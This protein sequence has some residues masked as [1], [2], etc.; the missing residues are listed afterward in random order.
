M[1]AAI[2]IFFDPDARAASGGGRIGAAR[3]VS[4]GAYRGGERP[5]RAVAGPRLCSFT[6]TCSR[7]CRAAATLALSRTGWLDR[8]RPSLQLVHEVARKTGTMTITATDPAT[9]RRWQ[10]DPSADLG[11]RQLK[12]PLYVPGHAA[13]VHA[14]QTRRAARPG[15]QRSDHHRRLALLAERRRRPP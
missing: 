11:D 14:L 10:I 15:R 6:S 12:K 7:S 13:A 1:T 2:T 8:G 5:A 9:G 4:A 3:V